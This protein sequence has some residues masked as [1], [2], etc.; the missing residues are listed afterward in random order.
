M[1]ATCRPADPPNLT[2]STALLISLHGQ[3]DQG[4]QSQGARLHHRPLLLP[5]GGHDVHLQRG[6]QLGAVLTV[7]TPDLVSVVCVE[8]GHNV[9]RVHRIYI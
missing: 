9:A 4:E 3:P 2:G 8:I 5:P 6:G 1:A 7:S